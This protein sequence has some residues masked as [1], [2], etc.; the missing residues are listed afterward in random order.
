MIKFFRNVRKNLLNQGKTANYLKYAIGEIALVVIGILIALQV[1]NWNIDR[2]DRKSEQKYLKNIKE[3]L[4]KDLVNLSY[5]INFR[6]ERIKGDG[7][8]I[9]QINGPNR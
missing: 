5:L 1:N 7:K 2:V 3:D 6:K 4:E 9:E 8:L